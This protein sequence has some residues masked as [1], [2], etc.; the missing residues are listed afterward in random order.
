VNYP[1]EKE[2]LVMHARIIEETGGAHG[3]RDMNLFVSSCNR[4]KMIFGGKELYPDVHKK[5][6]TYVESF[7]M[8][9]VF[10]D[11]NKRTGIIASARFLFLNSYELTADNKEIE[12]FALSVV[13]DKLTLEQIAKWIKENSSSI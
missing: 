1:S 11:G 2:I 8:N 7:I 4:S 12:N 6:A 10:I 9:H 13:V 3:V 5:A